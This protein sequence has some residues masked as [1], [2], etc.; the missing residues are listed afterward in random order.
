MP[1]KK[2]LAGLAIAAMAVG[3][4]AL[5][6]AP[7]QAGCTHSNLKPHTVYNVNCSWAQHAVERQSVGW[8]YSERVG[9]CTTASSY[10]YFDETGR[11]GVVKSGVT[12]SYC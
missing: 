5:G 1:K 4:A 8:V 7:A 9:P 6:A 3:C 12:V 10:A 2:F 11:Y